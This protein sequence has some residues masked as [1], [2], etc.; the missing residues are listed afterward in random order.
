MKILALDTSSQACSTAMWIDGAVIEHFELLE[1]GHSK[2]ILPMIEAVLAEAGLVLRQCDALA[3]GR[4]PGSFTGIRIGVG[5]AQ[6]LA[7][8][9]DLP[10]VPVSSLAALAY[11]Q[12]ARRVLAAF[13]ARIGQIYWGAF[14]RGPRGD[15]IVVRGEAVSEP[16]SVSVD[17]EGWVGA[18]S[19]FDRYAERL[20]ARLRTR[21]TGWSPRQVPHARD[22]AALGARD[23]ANGLSV[24]ASGAVPEYVRDRV[25]RTSGGTL[26]E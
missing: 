10:T 4:G 7:Y 25:A 26:A 14:A 19:G 16:E 24:P 20:G 11:G 21:L 18:G 3:F 1:R 2:R 13:D 9:A 6:G 12:P 23:F 17:G 8:G 15:S 5:A 22:V